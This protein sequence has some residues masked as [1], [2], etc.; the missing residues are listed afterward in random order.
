MCNYINE[1]KFFEWY[2]SIIADKNYSRD[3][4]LTDIFTFH[5]MTRKMV[6]EVP[7]SKTISGVAESYE[8]RAENIGCCGASTMFIKF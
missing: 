3:G 2:D 1:D 5:C 4:V 6:F 8:F 7:A